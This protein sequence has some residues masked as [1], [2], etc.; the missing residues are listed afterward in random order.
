[1][2]IAENAIA[3]CC[4]D[5]LHCEI[6]GYAIMCRMETKAENKRYSHFDQLSRLIWYH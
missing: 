4:T 6:E 5:V 3:L 2:S 1:L